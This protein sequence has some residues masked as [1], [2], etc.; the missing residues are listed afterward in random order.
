MTCTFVMR[1]DV[2]GRGLCTGCKNRGKMAEVKDYYKAL[3]VKEKASAEEIKKAYRKLAREYHPDR[4]PDK[5]HAEERFK[6][7][8][9]AYDVLSDPE[10]RKQ[11]D[12]MRKNPFGAF[13]GFDTS[14]GGRYY[15]APDGTYVRFDQPGGDGGGFDLGDLGGSFSD[16][17]SRFFGGA[18]EPRED[19]FTQ[20]RRN[21]AHAGRDVQTKVHLTFEQALQGGKTEVVLPDGTRVRLTI[22]RGVRPGFKVRLRGQGEADPGGERGDLYVTFE[23][24]SNPEFRREGND[25]LTTVTVNA[26]EAMLGTKRGISNAYGQQ[27]KLT[28]PAG[29]QPGDRLRLREQ[30]VVTDHGTGD[31]YVEIAVSIPRNLTPEQ[32][33]IL[34]KVAKEGGLL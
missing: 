26:F 10:K 13:G 5:P 27:I 29:T 6:E 24:E 4:N 17:F 23:V 28:I 9:E 11:Y 16:L 7:I 34:R 18:A 30:G 22:P 2:T 19:P 33:E 31:L 25:L 21:R 8:Q 20:A 1:G 3:G 12:V 15:R 14:R 32:Q